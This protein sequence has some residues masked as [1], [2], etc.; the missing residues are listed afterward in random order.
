MLVKYVIAHK[1]TEECCLFNEEN[2]PEQTSTGAKCSQVEFDPVIF[3]YLTGQLDE[4]FQLGNLKWMNFSTASRYHYLFFRLPTVL[5][6]MAALI[7][8]EAVD[9]WKEQGGGSKNTIPALIQLLNQEIG[10]EEKVQVY[11]GLIDPIL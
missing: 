4:V 7:F 3:I 11:R 6:P 1:A 8:D 9:T 10:D 2:L 5:G